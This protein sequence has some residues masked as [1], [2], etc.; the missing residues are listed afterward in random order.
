MRRILLAAATLASL[1][2]AAM[3]ISAQ[4]ATSVGISIRIGD[5]YRGATLRFHSA[6]RV[7]LVPT[8]RVYAVRDY[9]YDLYRY[10]DDWYYVEDGYWYCADS[11]RGPFVRVRY[12]SVPYDVRYVCDRGG[13]RSFSS[14]YRSYRSGPPAHAPAWGYRAK[15]RSHDRDWDRDRVRTRSWDRDRERSRDRSWDRTRTRDRV[16]ENDRKWRDRDR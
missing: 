13:Y 4:A 16:R 12:T 10:D 1:A 6:P 3:P 8:T 2:M 14:G 5:P 11:Y 15:Y 9:D 7:I